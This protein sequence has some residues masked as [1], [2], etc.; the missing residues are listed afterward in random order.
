MSLQELLPIARSVV[1]AGEDV[2]ILLRALHPTTAAAVRLAV[3]HTPSAPASV[4]ASALLAPLDGLAPAAHIATLEPA[5]QPPIVAYSS[6]RT[7]AVPPAVSGH[8]AASTINPMAALQPFL[9]AQALGATA[10]NNTT[11]PRGRRSANSGQS[12]RPAPY[13]ISQA[14]QGRNAAIVAHRPAAPAR[15]PRSRAQSTPRVP[16]SDT[17]REGVFQINSSNERA[18][19][20]NVLIFLPRVGFFACF[21]L[22]S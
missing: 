18:V 22:L 11:Q 8:P 15:T 20:L 9:G 10:T 6:R 16:P 4:P 21:R 13:D 14:N 19:R 12:R 3:A 1:A 2:E 17:S 5:P 7:Q